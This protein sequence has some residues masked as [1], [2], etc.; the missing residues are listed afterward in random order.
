M[1]TLTRRKLGLGTF[2]CPSEVTMFL[3]TEREQKNRE[4]C[5]KELKYNEGAANLAEFG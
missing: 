2:L 1:S 3:P 4:K 5:Q